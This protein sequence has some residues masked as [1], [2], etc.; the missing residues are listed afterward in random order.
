MGVNVCCIGDEAHHWATVDI[1]T[2]TALDKASDSLGFILLH[3]DY[4]FFSEYRKV[5][6]NK[7]KPE[8][9]IRAG[10]VVKSDRF[11]SNGKPQNA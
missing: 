10:F 8:S 7:Q 6:E 4:S 1:P 9:G 3:F 5:V 11:I 2:A